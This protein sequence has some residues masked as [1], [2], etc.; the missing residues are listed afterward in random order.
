MPIQ[1]VGHV[2]LKMR[3]LDEAK[4]FYNGVLG[5]KIADEREDMGVFF[6]STTITTISPSLRSA[7]MPP[8][9]SAIRS[10]SPMSP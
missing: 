9:R 10:G 6:D 4:R 7:K 8:R 1:R 2:V 3:D 5:M